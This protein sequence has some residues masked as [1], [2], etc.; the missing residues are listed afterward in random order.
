MST[1]LKKRICC[2]YWTTLLHFHVC[3]IISMQLETRNTEIQKYI[4]SFLCPVEAASLFKMTRY[5]IVRTTGSRTWQTLRCS[6]R[7]LFLM[8][9]LR[10]VNF[11]NTS[12]VSVLLFRHCRLNVWQ[13]Q[14]LAFGID[15]LRRVGSRKRSFFR[16]WW[17]CG[18]PAGRFLPLAHVLGRICSFSS[19]FETLYSQFQI[20][21]NY[22]W[23]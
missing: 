7:I 21:S 10:L 18:I 20:F 5:W 17:R 15:V 16:Q 9:V 12:C 14:P 22:W 3:L 1:I 13:F 4:C 8:G 19:A 6:S 11:D 2:S 23:L